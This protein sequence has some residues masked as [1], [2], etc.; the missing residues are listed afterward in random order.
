MIG[1][2]TGQGLSAYGGGAG[3]YSEGHWGLGILGQA[4][5]TGDSMAK[6]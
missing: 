2:T 5:I 1:G 6:C 4:G 3:G